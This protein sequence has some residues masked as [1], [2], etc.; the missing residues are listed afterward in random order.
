MSAYRHRTRAFGLAMLASLAAA[1]AGC[2]PAKPEQDYSRF[3]DVWTS[4][5]PVAKEQ[6]AEYLI[7]QGDLSFC[8]VT[9]HSQTDADYASGEY[10]VE[11]KRLTLTFVFQGGVRKSTEYT[12]LS[13][14]PGAL[15]LTEAAP[16]V[17][18]RLS[19]AHT[20]DYTSCSD[21]QTRFGQ[22]LKIL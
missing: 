1:V 8:R 10:V 4:T 19:L 16:T 2:T 17:G 12:I 18:R 7:F 5:A 6:P 20:R 15:E 21:A 9:V 14:K 3:I 22:K 13:L 11:D